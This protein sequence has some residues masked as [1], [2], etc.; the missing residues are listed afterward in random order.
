MGINVGAFAGPLICGFLGQ[1]WNWHWGFFRGRIRYGARADPIPSRV[2]PAGRR[3]RAAQRTNG[4]GACQPGAPLLRRM[5]RACARPGRLWRAGVSRYHPD[6]AYSDS[7]RS[8]RGDHRRRGGLLHIPDRLR[9]A[10]RGRAKEDCGDLLVRAA[11]RHLLVRLRAGGV[12]A[13]SVRRGL[14]QPHDRALELPGVM[15]PVGQRVLHRRS[16]AGFR[17]ALGLARPSATRIPRPRSS[18]RSV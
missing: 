3:G 14:H 12:F 6:N 13:D 1:G 2:R 4:S 15:V 17:L 16:G 11:G 5:R 18:S 10:R 8:G 9:R 7:G